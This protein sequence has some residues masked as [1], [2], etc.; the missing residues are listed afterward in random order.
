MY[1]YIYLYL[2]PSIIHTSVKHE[3]FCSINGTNYVEQQLINEIE[4]HDLF[5]HINVYTF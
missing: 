2:Q 1:I 3:D 5:L 4:R